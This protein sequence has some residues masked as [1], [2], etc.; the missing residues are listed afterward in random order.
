M[1]TPSGDMQMPERLAIQLQIRDHASVAPAISSQGGC[2]GLA[3]SHGLDQ[4]L[5]DL[6]TAVVDRLGGFSIANAHTDDTSWP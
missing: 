5:G 1:T 4:W 2:L 6:D 3:S